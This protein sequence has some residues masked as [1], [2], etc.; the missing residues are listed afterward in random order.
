MSDL[1]EQL[2][3]LPAEQIG[4]AIARLAGRILATEP[5]PADELLTP[6]EA[7]KRLRVDRRWVY[8]H[9]RE[10]GAVRFGRKL[11]VPRAGVQRFVK[12]SRSG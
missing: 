7:A 11:R 1:L 2:D 9:A 6:E 4:A 3:Q 5:E 10:L 12:R 8:R